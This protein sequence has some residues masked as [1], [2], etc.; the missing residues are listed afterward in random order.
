MERAMVAVDTHAKAPARSKRLIGFLERDPTNLQL[1][2]DAAAAAMDEGAPEVALALMDR[3]AA[4]APLPPSLLNLKGIAALKQGRY[5]DA[6]EVF[7]ALLAGNPDDCAVRFNLAW[8]RSM[9]EDFEGAS[10]VL[11]DPT[12]DAVPGAAVLKVRA[13]HH[14]G[15]LDEALELGDRQLGSSPGNAELVGALAAVAIDAGKIDVA[16]RFGVAAGDNAEG[17]STLG[18]LALG[19]EQVDESIAL[20]DRALG[21][22]PDN[23]RALLGRGLALLATGDEAAAASY[24][25]RAAERFGSH[26]GSW[27]AAGWVYYVLGDYPASRARFE[28]ALALDD[29]FAETQGGL[30]ALDIVDG[31]I[32]SARRR[33]Q[34]ALRLDRK[35]FGGALAMSQLMVLDGNEKGA[36]RVRNTALNAPIGLN[37]QTIAQAVAG[38]GR[39]GRV[40]PGGR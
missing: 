7:E 33:T 26:L 13:L 37:G 29:T 35:C 9:L 20:F 10:K 11:D 23:A 2:G 31:Q 28:R 15:R 32:E 3:Y 17:L 19:D 40:K 1:I 38:F 27:V 18:M 14:L 34:V 12:I 16:R 8:S 22:H 30:A 36:E 4:I 5:G 6:A 21:A 39:A 24:I 25:D